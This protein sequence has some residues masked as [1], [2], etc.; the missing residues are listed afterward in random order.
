VVGKQNLQLTLHR[1][2]CNY[3]LLPHM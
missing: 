3:R 2:V 1:V